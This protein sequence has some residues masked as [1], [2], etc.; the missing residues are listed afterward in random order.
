MFINPD[1]LIDQDKVHGDDGADS[2]NFCV[3]LSPWFAL[4]RV[5]HFYSF[6]TYFSVRRQQDAQMAMSAPMMNFVT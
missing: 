6:A 5:S 3:Q 2:I 4:S 1:N